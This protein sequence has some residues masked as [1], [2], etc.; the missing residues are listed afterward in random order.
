VTEGE[1]RGTK[2]RNWFSFG[3]DETDGEEFIPYGGPLYQLFAM[4]APDIDEVLDDENLPERKYQQ[5]VK[6]AAKALETSPYK[7]A[8]A[9]QVH[10]E[11]R[12]RRQN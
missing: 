10:T 7:P 4:V 2:F 5:F 11:G 3:K 1:Y 8:L 6:R 9:S 12:S